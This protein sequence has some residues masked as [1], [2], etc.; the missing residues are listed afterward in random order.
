MIYQWRA[1]LLAFS[2]TSQVIKAVKL[3]K[4]CLYLLRFAGTTSQAGKVRRVVRG[5]VCLE[6]KITDCNLQVAN[7][8]PS[9]SIY[10]CRKLR[11][12]WFQTIENRPN[13][14]KVRCER[15]LGRMERREITF[16]RVPPQRSRSKLGFSSVS[17]VIALITQSRP[18]FEHCVQCEQ[19]R[20]RRSPFTTCKLAVM[21]S[22]K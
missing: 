21:I 10:F 14:V 9:G 22:R 8:N 13:S 15:S 19:L 3:L 20:S 6:K 2:K 17:S 11:N 5:K 12:Q 4:N 18:D 7:C 1:N 16:S